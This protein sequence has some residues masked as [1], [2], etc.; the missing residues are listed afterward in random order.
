[1]GG[2]LVDIHRPFAGC[3]RP[4]DLF[5]LVR[6]LILQFLNIVLTVVFS[7]VVFIV[8]PS[9]IVFIFM[10]AT[11]TMLLGICLAWAWGVIAMKAALAARP[12][13]D[14]QARLQALQ[15]AVVSRANVT[16]EPAAA[17]QQELIFDGFM[18]DARVTV[19]Y[20]VMV[21]LF[22]YF[23][24]GFLVPVKSCMPV[25]RLNRHAYA[26]RTRSSRWFRCSGRLFL[27]YFW[28][29]R[30]CYHRSRALCQKL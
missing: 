26:R 1:M 14:T 9:G 3:D 10:L 18:L 7:L 11:V 15:Q 12:A 20:F 13:S 8:P 29:L 17:I 2:D 22:I 24:V 27:T 28:S 25:L 23:L 21:C 30:P 16:G 19:I 6:A 4:S 5:C